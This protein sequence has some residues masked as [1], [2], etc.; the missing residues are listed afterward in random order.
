MKLRHPSCFTLLLALLAGP[1][2]ATS[3]GSSTAAAGSRHAPALEHNPGVATSNSIVATVNGRPILKSEVDDLMQASIMD[4]RRRVS[5]QE[6][7]D[8]EVKKLRSRILDTLIDQELILKEFEPFAATQNSRVEARAD[9]MIRKQFIDGMFKGDRR[10]FRK[11]LEESGMGYTKF[12]EQQKKNVIIEMMR[13][14]FAR[15]DTPYVTN[16]E[17]AAWLKKNGDLFRVGGKLKLWSITIPGRAEGKTVEQQMALAREVRTSLVDGA[18]F[19][20]QARTYSADSKRDA[21]GSWGLVDKKDLADQ[22]WP[23]VSS[24]PTGKISEIVPFQGSFYIF[25][26]EAREPGKMKPQAEIDAE[27]ERRVQ[28]EK[29]KKASDEWLEKLRKKATIVYPK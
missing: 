29:R 18:D 27:V 11:E 26:V 7:F 5:S 16:E 28:M 24:L 4:V 12:Y 3:G 8:S 19:A 20:S 13:S 15:T 1:A 25:W 10:K 2:L 9:E 23:I 22:F 17:K 6:E 21:G 14:Q